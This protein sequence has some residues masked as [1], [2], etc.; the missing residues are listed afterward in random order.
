MLKKL[1]KMFSMY[2][3]LPRDIYFIAIAK[4]ILG[5][6]NF[7]IPFMV[8]LLTQKQD[9]STS[10]AGT[11]VMIITGAYMLGSLIGGKLS[12]AYGHKNIMIIGELLGAVVIITCGFFA[13]NHF[14]SPALLCIGYFFIGVA[15]PAS[16]ALVADLSNPQN[17][18]AVMSLS[19]LAYNLGSGV[20]PV[21]AGYLF[22]NYTEWVY[23]GEGLALLTGILLVAFYVRDNA[24]NTDCQENVSEFEKNTNGNVWSIFKERPRLIV[25][26]LLCTML[27]FILN[28]MTMTSPLYYSHIF[29]KSGA[30][31]FGQLMT[32]ASLI[33]VFITPLL[34]KVTSSHSELSS[35]SI[36]GALFV[37]GYTLVV[38][39]SSI[40]MQFF[41]WF[42]LSAAEVLLIT[43]EGIYI[44][45]QS[46]AS[47][48]GRISS[49]LLTIR[50]IGLMPTYVI[51]GSFIQSFGYQKAWLL[52]I[53]T[54]ILA[55]ISFWALYIQQ[56]RHFMVM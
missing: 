38:S 19:Y 30:I 33:V 26:G 8:L 17:R 24:I 16:N 20:G 9:Y 18:D 10:V 44:A 14:I 13:E 23:W 32:F 12:D 31:L 6:G 5:L 49:I 53:I 28:Q 7:I 15:L 34:M 42:F 41:A 46:P 35:L 56:K 21:I 55:T 22:W 11:I 51:M 36:A 47:H 37:V 4:F 27:W 3:G 54:A 2:E 25:F 52:V 50:N 40:P 1:D 43:K 29:D 48:R 39:C 45:N